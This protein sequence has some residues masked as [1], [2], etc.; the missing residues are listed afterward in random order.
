MKR[1]RPAQVANTTLANFTDCECAF[2]LAEILG[3][4]VEAVHVVLV[5][6]PGGGGEVVDLEYTVDAASAAEAE[7]LVDVAASSLTMAAL[8][9][10]IRELATTARLAVD[11]SGAAGLRA[12]DGAS[13][14]PYAV[15]VVAGRRRLDDAAAACATP[16]AP[17]TLDPVW[18]A[19]CAWD[20]VP[21]DATLL[22]AVYDA[23]AGEAA[24]DVLGYAE[25]PLGPFADAGPVQ[26]DVA[27][28][29][30]SPGTVSVRVDFVVF[31]DATCADVTVERVSLPA[32]APAPTAAPTAP[33]TAGAPEEGAFVDGDAG[34]APAEPEPDPCAAICA[35]RRR[36]RF[37]T[38][39]GDDDGC[40]C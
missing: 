5:T 11:V 27:F 12:G 1:S 3:V 26:R 4:E 24:D 40:A 15:L 10:K 8:E 19:S 13:S 25:L 6:A 30:G 36:L 9:A 18:D 14:D 23:D 16:V 35:R 34:F 22:L 29:D 33:P 28:D 7:H 21:S 31:S 2:A 32:V 37:G 38:F 39:R 20:A 17:A